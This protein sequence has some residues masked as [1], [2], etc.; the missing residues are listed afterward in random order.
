MTLH[1]TG[2][3]QGSKILK[4]C[5]LFGEKRCSG[6]NSKVCYCTFYD[7]EPYIHVVSGDVVTFLLNVGFLI[8]C[9]NNTCS[10]PG[11]IV[12]RSN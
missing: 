10:V 12:H 7:N 1:N 6:N 4:A 5:I 2:S 8:R 11:A 9:N 3:I